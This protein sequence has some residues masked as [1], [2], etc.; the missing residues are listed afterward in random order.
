MMV[1][2][3]VLQH[4]YTRYLVKVEDFYNDELISAFL[5]TEQ[6]VAESANAALRNTYRTT[7]RNNKLSASNKLCKIKN[8]VESSLN[9]SEIQL[10]TPLASNNKDA[11]YNI[12]TGS[13]INTGD[14][15]ITVGGYFNSERGISSG[16][17]AINTNSLCAAYDKWNPETVTTKEAIMGYLT[18]LIKEYNTKVYT[19]NTT[20]ITIS[21]YIDEFKRLLLE[22]TDDRLVTRCESCGTSDC[23]STLCVNHATDDIHNKMMKSRT[24]IVERTMS[25]EQMLCDYVKQYHYVKDIQQAIIDYSNTLKTQ[26]NSINTQGNVR[27]SF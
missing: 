2:F 22:S 24:L 3:A 27:L 5:N 19:L 25:L 11:I 12:F 18:A 13:A 7:V 9:I 21:E 17:G 1:L 6:R 16:S 23:V 4:V 15:P 10:P 14:V 8:L 20:K 26:L